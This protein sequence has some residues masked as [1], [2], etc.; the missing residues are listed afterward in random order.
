MKVKWK[1]RTEQNKIQI[2]PT[3]KFTQLSITVI[4]KLLQ[5]LS[6]FKKDV[7]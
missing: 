2:Y 7:S 4:R 6:C 3:I 1:H 5:S